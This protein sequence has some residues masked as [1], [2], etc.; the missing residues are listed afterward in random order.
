[1]EKR[2]VRRGRKEG[3]EEGQEKERKRE[4]LITEIEERRKRDKDREG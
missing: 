3:R 2:K 4:L 1:M